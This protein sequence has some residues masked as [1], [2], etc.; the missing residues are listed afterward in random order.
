MRHA[1][2]PIRGRSGGRSDRG[3]GLH[4]RRRVQATALTSC[5]AAICSRADGNV[6]AGVATTVMAASLS[7]RSRSK[8]SQTVVKA[9]RDTCPVNHTLPLQ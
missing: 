9:T 2:L 3:F 8:A 7:D 5:G 4:G 1:D 6:L